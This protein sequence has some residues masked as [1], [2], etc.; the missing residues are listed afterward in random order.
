M[1]KIGLLIIT[2]CFLLVGCTKE[3]SKIEVKDST[4]DSVENKVVSKEVKESKAIKEPKTIVIDPGHS[5]IGNSDKEP[6]APGS[7]ILKAKDVHGATGTTT[8]IP[9]YKTVLNISLLLRS[10]LESRGY[11]VVMTKT[12]IDDSIS[13]IE[14]ANIGNNNNAD[15]VMRIHCDASNDSGV[16]GASMQIPA[17]TKY[18]SLIYEKSKCYGET[19]INTFSNSLGLKNRGVVYR[20]DLTG[21]NWS[22]VPV[23]LLETGFLSNPKDDKFISDENNHKIIAKAIADGID[24]SFL[25]K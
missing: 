8:K 24:K 19:I 2:I 4:K 12:K 17:N 9:E 18:T 15:L 7:N 16:N 1:K 25:E 5:S 21:F 20:E 6:T 13:N 14:R 23:V 11:N 22:N 10:E 3:Y